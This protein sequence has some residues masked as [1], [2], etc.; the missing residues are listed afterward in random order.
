M[1]H[2]IPLHNRQENYDRVRARIFNGKPIKRR[3][4]RIR[5]KFRERRRQRRLIIG[6][7]LRAE[8][9][10]PDAR[11][12]LTVTVN[13]LSVRGLLD[14]GASVSILGNGCRE[15]LDKLNI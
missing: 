15:I 4:I 14:S 12:F 5:E 10:R 2:Y 6:S 13:G 3:M 1:R 7:I 8:K 11:V 9:G